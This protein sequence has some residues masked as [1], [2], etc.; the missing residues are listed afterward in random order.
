VRYYERILDVNPSVTAGPPVGLG[1]RFKKGG[2]VTVDEWE[3]LRGQT[4][5]SIAYLLPRHVRE[6]MLK[7]VGYTQ[8]NI[9]DAVRIVV[10]VQHQRRTTVATLKS[11]SVE[12]AIEKATRRVKGLLSFGR[13]TKS[14]W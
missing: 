6:A 12:E 9:A 10:K 13:N 5:K 11:A 1:W 7:E 14:L 2:E 8:R 4:Q 3:L